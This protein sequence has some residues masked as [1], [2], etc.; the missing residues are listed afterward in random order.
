[1]ITITNVQ[2]NNDDYQV[3]FQCDFINSNETE[4]DVNDA[5]I[6]ECMSTRVWDDPFSGQIRLQRGE[7]SS[8]GLVE[9]YC[10]DRWGTVCDDLFTQNSGDTV[11]NQLGYTDAIDITSEIQGNTSQ[12][13]WLTNTNCVLVYS[14]LTSCASCPSSDERVTNCGHQEDVNVHC[15]YESTSSQFGGTLTTCDFTDLAEAIGRLIGII[16]GVI[17]AFFVIVAICITLPI[18]ICCC[19]GVG[20]GAAAAKA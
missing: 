15:A 13:I 14:C 6:V 5:V 7:F 10:N 20:I 16:V 17:I 19:L 1:M 12:P 4:C 2:C 18:C 3:L 11:C 9:I 8:E